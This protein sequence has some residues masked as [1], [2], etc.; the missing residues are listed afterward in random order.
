MLL[1]NEGTKREEN[2]CRSIKPLFN[3]EPAATH[4]D[5]QAAALQFVRKVSGYRKPS[6]VNEAAFN[7]AVAEITHAAE[8]LL[9]DLETRAEPKVRETYVHRH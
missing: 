4:D 2:M 6:K 1:Y 7:K 3:Y 9:A 8:H 5:V